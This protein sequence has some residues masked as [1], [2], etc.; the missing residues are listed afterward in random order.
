M[1]NTSIITLSVTQPSAAVFRYSTS[2]ADTNGGNQKIITDWIICTK[3]INLLTASAR[4]KLLLAYTLQSNKVLKCHGV[5]VTMSD[6]KTVQKIQKD[7]IFNENLIL[8]WQT[9]KMAKCVLLW[10]VQSKNGQIFRNWPWNG[11]SGSPVLLYAQFHAVSIINVQI[12]RWTV[13]LDLLHGGLRKNLQ[14]VIYSVATRLSLVNIRLLLFSTSDNI[15]FVPYSFTAATCLHYH[16]LLPNKP[17]K[18]R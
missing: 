15:R 9:K 12:E 8:Q 14:T 1:Q 16:Y 6:M 5:A 10:P 4:A 13:L 11:Q 3:S 18:P 7:K 17:N 2:T